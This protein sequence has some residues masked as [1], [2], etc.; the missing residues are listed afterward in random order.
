[1]VR[2]PEEETLEALVRAG[3]ATPAL[4]E[5]IARLVAAFHTN[6]QTDE[7]IA[8]FGTLEVIRTN[9]EENFVQMQPYIGRALDASIYEQ[10]VGY[11][12]HFLDKRTALF[13]SRIQDGHI[14]D[15]HGDLRLQHVY[16]LDTP[17]KAGHQLAILDCIEFNERFRYGDVASEVA[18]LAMELDDAGQG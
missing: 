1:M 11:I 13:T 14:R 2:L 18:F 17:D 6:S 12:R 8:S 3:T 10:I 7:Q 16:S 4:L 5:E 15:C 9:W